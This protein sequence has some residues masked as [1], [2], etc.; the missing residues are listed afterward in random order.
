MDVEIKV[1][2]YFFGRRRC[3]YTSV[4]GEYVSGYGKDE[5]EAIERLIT[6]CTDLIAGNQI[7]INRYTAIRDAALAAKAK[8]ES[9]ATDEQ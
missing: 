2:E 5:P 3:A 1:A 7:K 4:D 9:E 8:L 6:K